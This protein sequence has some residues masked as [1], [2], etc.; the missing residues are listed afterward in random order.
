MSNDLTWQLLLENIVEQTK[1][2]EDFLFEVGIILNKQLL[3]IE[4]IFGLLKKDIYDKD[5]HK[6]FEKVVKSITGVPVKFKINEEFNATTTFE[7]NWSS[8]IKSF[9][10]IRFDNNFNN[11]LNLYKINDYVEKI[12]IYYGDD[13]IR[14]LNSKELTAVFLHELGHTYYL[15]SMLRAILPNI[16]RYFARP[17]A[18]F[19]FLSKGFDK[20]L[21]VSFLLML[22]SKGLTFL[23]HMEENKAD[24]F[25][26]KYGYGDELINVFKKCK[27][28][29]KKDPTIFEKIM[30]ELSNLISTNIIFSGKH[31]S[32][33]KRIN[34]I[35]S[36]IKNKYIDLYPQY[37][38]PLINNFKQLNLAEAK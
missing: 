31:P 24:K 20:F 19:T 11:N 2:S 33:N 3:E 22:V 4:H 17:I 38:E 13:L 7:Y 35:M 8:A 16:L 27:T 30:E 21:V 34:K 29:K 5:A 26:V 37:K 36:N 28:K 12:Y 15:P 18:F 14:R 1:E 32:D 10:M 9:L 23:D 25:V 6:N